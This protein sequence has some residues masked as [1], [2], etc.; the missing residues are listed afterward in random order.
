MPHPDASDQTHSAFLFERFCN[1]NKIPIQPVP[2]QEGEK[3]P[4]FDIFPNG[5]QIVAEI[6]E[7]SANETD[8]LLIKEIKD[9]GSGASCQSYS[10]R[11]RNLI[12]NAK[13]QLK[14]RAKNR[15]PAVLVLYDRTPFKVILPDAIKEAMYGNEVVSFDKSLDGQERYQVWFGSDAQFTK[16]NNTTFSALALLEERGSNG[17]HLCFFHNIHAPRL[18]SIFPEWLRCPAVSHFSL[19]DPHSRRYQDWVE[20]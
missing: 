11:V 10:R 13:D 7:A 19:P 3:T 6:K 9:T 2:R 20:I 15:H 1:E 16:N 12:Y 8:E 4:D 18:L 5:H 17:L 14:A